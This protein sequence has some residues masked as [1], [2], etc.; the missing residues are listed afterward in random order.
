MKNLCPLDEPLDFSAQTHWE[1]AAQTRIGKY[2]TKLETDF[3]TKSIDFNR[4]NLTVMDVG[5]EAGRFSLFAA[6][7]NVDVVSIDL[8]LYALKRLK[9]KNR[10]VNI[11]QADATHLPIKDQ[12]LDAVLL[13]EVLDYI[14]ELNQTLTDCARVLKPD[15]SCILSFGNNSSLK[16]KIKAV[17]G[18]SYRH[19]SGEVMGSLSQTGL[20]IINKLGYNWLPFGRTS[21]NVLVPFMANIE[22]IFGLRRI[23]RFSPWVILAATKQSKT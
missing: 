9:A 18:T 17:K 19:S 3:I 20:K 7:A 1:I 6:K 2:L 23:V 10:L 15:A 8:N 21:Q 22:R 14:S 12:V 16:A 11:V 5:A 4:Q 13:I